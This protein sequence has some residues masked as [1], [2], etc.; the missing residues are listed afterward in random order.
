MMKL[1]VVIIIGLDNAQTDHC[2]SSSSTSSG[3]KKKSKK[4]VVSRALLSIPVKHQIETSI[5]TGQ[6]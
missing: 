3:W 2:L 5:A 6:E 1:I 4:H